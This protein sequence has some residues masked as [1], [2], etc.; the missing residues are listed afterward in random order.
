MNWLRITDKQ[1]KM[2]TNVLVIFESNYCTLV[3]WMPH[4]RFLFFRRSEVLRREEFGEPKE[5]RN[6]DKFTF[7]KGTEFK[8]MGEYMKT[9]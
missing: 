3:R 6:V 5:W 7:K 4:G 9:I 1:P 8:P 2:H